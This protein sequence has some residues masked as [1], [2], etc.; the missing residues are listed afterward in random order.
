MATKSKPLWAGEAETFFDISRKYI[1]QVVLRTI[2][3]MT[4]AESARL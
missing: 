2:F 4:T 1:R 3:K